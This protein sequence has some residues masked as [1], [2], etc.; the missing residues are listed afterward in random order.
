MRVLC[1]LVSLTACFSSDRAAQLQANVDQATKSEAKSLLVPPGDYNFGN[2]TFLIQVLYTLG[3]TA[4]ATAAVY[5]WCHRCCNCRCMPLVPLLL[6]PLLCVTLGAIRGPKTWRSQRQAWGA[7]GGIVLRNC[8]NV[9]FKGFSLDR[10]P[11]PFFQA[12]AVA[13]SNDLCTF[14]IEN[15]TVDQGCV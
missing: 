13:I 9:K 10:N 5:P 12:Q 4:A 14:Q 8:E 15:G 1:L 2:R 7:N 6:P 3:A 11:A